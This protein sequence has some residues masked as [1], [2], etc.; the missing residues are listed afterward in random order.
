MRPPVA[1]RPII[2]TY[3]APRPVYSAARVVAVPSPYYMVV[4]SGYT[5][6]DLAY[7]AEPNWN[8]TPVESIAALAG[9]AVADRSDVR[10]Y[11]PDTR[12]Y[13]PLVETC[14]SPWLKVIP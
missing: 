9:R 3:V 10:F 1:I 12:E 6:T 7:P 2:T 8:W 14:P 13:Y 5:G 11:C 4:D